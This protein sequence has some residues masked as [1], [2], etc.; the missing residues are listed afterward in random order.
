MVLYWGS[1]TGHPNRKT[2]QMTDIERR[3]FTFTSPDSHGG[4]QPPKKLL[5]GQSRRFLEFPDVNFLLQVRGANEKR[6]CAGPPSD[7]Q[8]GSG[9]KCEAQGQPGMQW[10]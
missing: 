2:E 9:D 8:G 7:K 4:L 1:A 10:P 3:S 6:C 5:K